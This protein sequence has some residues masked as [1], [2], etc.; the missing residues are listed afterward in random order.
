MSFQPEITSKGS[1]SGPSMSKNKPVWKWVGAILLG[2][3]I[4]GVLVAA[5]IWSNRY[6][7]LE[8][9]AI[10]TLEERGIEAQLS[11]KR[12]NFDTLQVDNVELTYR[13]ER[14]PF[15][16]AKRIEADY[17]LKE[18]LKGNMKRLRLMEPTARITLDENFKITDG[19]LPP[20]S[21]SSPGGLSIPE[22]GFFIEDATFN[23]ETPYGSPEISMSASIRETD[24]FEA[25][26]VID[27]TDLDYKDWALTGS[28]RLDLDVKGDKKEI[29]SLIRLQSLSRYD[30]NLNEATLEV[31]GALMTNTTLPI[32]LE[33]L[34]MTFTGDIEGTAGR[35]E[36]APFT[37]DESQF[38][39]DGQITRQTDLNSPIGLD[40]QID[41]STEQ[42][43]FADETRAKNLA[44]MLTLSDPLSSTPIAQHFAPSLTKTLERL[45][46]QS[47]IKTTADINFKNEKAVI[48][49]MNP[50]DAVRDNIE[51][52]ISG[53]DQ[54][55]YSWNR[56]TD[57]LTLSFDAALNRPVPMTLKNT[58]IEADTVNGWQL[59]NITKFLGNMNTTESWKVVSDKEP[60]RLAPFK[61]VIDYQAETARRLNIT[62]GVDFDGRIPGGY[63]KGF[64]T[65][66][67]VNLRLPPS[68]EQGLML[69]YAPNRPRVNIGYFETET[70]W[71]LQN[72][73]LDLADGN[74]IFSLIG[75]NAKIG[76]GLE[77]VRFNALNKLDERDFD[78][79]LE[80]AQAKGAL[81]TQSGYQNW[82]I[83][84]DNA[85]MQS[86]N[87]PVQDTSTQVPR[88]MLSV[89]RS[90][91]NITFDFNSDSID[92][93]VPQV[94]VN[95][96]KVHAQGTPEDYRAEH[97]GGIFKSE[98][99]DI[100][101]WPV[102]G[103]VRF[104]EGKFT[105]DAVA[106]IPKANN[107]P[108]NIE[109]SFKDGAGSAHAVLESLTFKTGGLQPQTIAPALAGKVAAV[110]GTISA[111]MEVSFA[112]GEVQ[113]SGGVLNIMDMN[114]G[115]APGPVEG[116]NT[117][118]EFSS[119][120]P[121][122]TA[123]RQVMTVENFDPG[124][125]LEDGIIEYELVPEGVK[126]YSAQWP[127]N[128]GAFELDPFTWRYGADENRVV[129]RLNDIS[130]DEL[131]QSVGNEKLEATGT[132]RGVFPIVVRGLNV[133][134]DDGYLEAKDGGIIRFKS[135]QSQEATDRFQG[136][137]ILDTWSSGD[138]GVYNDLARE[139][140]R[141]FNYRELT[142]SIDGPLD[143]DVE[144]GVIFNGAN[145]K[146]LNGQPFEF[147]INVQG[148]L[149]NILRSFNSNSQIKS[150]LLKKE[151]DKQK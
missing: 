83:I 76:A 16:T 95:G 141:E 147:D 51:L 15:F 129:M 7:V 144:L 119:L 109:Y 149:F 34:N 99:L 146:V 48:T 28:A 24:Q 61:T 98:T 94:R 17:V 37:L 41:L 103:T 72:I 96:M 5:W 80:T 79:E 126:I 140:L 101:N 39:W 9:Y 26:L 35:L 125:P 58:R 104:A 137:R 90:N 12:A 36:T 75:K 145:K 97:S 117:Q 113:G 59:S 128:V 74:N 130:I 6:S 71:D 134:V 40:G 106:R 47:S 85:D 69:S 127:L 70:D 53:T 108:L 86:D 23:L 121:F 91:N 107:T 13:S 14:K 45:L 49:L 56:I 135:E 63:V 8:Q 139:A 82:T 65:A 116:L 102:S 73:T 89:L 88:G 67:R 25:T 118:I 148:E 10:T 114:F 111:D 11:I 1:K 64:E 22:S 143:G 142:A 84:F 68:G 33:T 81:N 110:E 21:E 132:V 52:E 66:G 105:G 18:A 27:E 93:S 133:L 62:G 151:A 131:L 20:K 3:F 112:K 77:N 44:Q 57:D 4:I 54:P 46:K 120:M 92:V 43:T 55:I 123:G 100:P 78:M 42:F 124:I 87:F 60:T 150:E 31:K 19:W 30:L 32:E 38:V 115:T 50:L 29:D 138:E 122:Q 136:D 2:V